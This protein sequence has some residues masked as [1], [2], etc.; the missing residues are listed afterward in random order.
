MFMLKTIWNRIYES[1]F[2]NGSRQEAG[3]NG[4]LKTLDGELD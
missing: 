3:I 1:I 2:T 4:E